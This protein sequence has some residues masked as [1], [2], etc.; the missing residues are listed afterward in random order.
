MSHEPAPY[1]APKLMREEHRP[2]AHRLQQALLAHAGKAVTVDQAELLWSNYSEEYWAAGW[3]G[4]PADDAELAQAVLGLFPVEVAQPRSATP[5]PL[6]EAAGAGGPMSADA[7]P[8]T[9]GELEEVTALAELL[10]QPYPGQEPGRLAVLLRR[11]VYG[12]TALRARLD[13]EARAAGEAGPFFVG[14]QRRAEELQLEY[15]AMKQRAE[16][17]EARVKEE[18]AA[19]AEAEREKLALHEELRGLRVE[20]AGVPLLNFP[21]HKPKHT[22]EQYFCLCG[23]DDVVLL[24]WASPSSG[25]LD[26][27]HDEACWCEWDGNVYEPT[28][29]SVRGF[30][31]HPKAPKIDPPASPVGRTA[32]AGEGREGVGRG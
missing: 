12:T 15:F 23:P 6:V 25:L 18:Q 1:P 29:H 19:A 10:A 7:V 3:M 8:L 11:A 26:D 2:D 24:M 31:P 22:E 14:F 4:M 16:K 13:A 20:L 28:A 17:A 21:R 5:A 30:W 32:G 27:T 9:S